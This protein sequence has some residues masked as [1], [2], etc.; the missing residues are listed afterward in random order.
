MT[1]AREVIAAATALG[2]R[3]DLCGDRLRVT[4]PG[5]LPDAVVWELRRAK[6]DIM[7]LLSGGDDVAERAVWCDRYAA[8]IAHCCLRAQPPWQEA[9]RFAFGELILAWHRRHG[10][11]PDPGRCAGC[12]DDLAGASGPTV[13]S[14]GT[15]VHFDVVRGVHCLIAFGARWRSAAVA[16]LEALG[17]V[18]PPGFELT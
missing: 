11:S 18:P 13:D 15:C 16:G 7:R 1:A 12:G 9:E 4:A 14:D 10:A 5:P 8:R 3:F 17:I 2:A 6:P